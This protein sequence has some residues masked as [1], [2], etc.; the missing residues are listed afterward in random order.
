MAAISVL[1]SENPKISGKVLYCGSL[2]FH[3]ANS[4]EQSEALIPLRFRRS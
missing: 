1:I 2:R 3:P 4:S